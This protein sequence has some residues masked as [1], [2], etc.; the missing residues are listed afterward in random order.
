M[1]PTTDDD[2]SLGTLTLLF[3]LLLGN[4][5]E[6]GASEE[7]L[8]HSTSWEQE[9][10]VRWDLTSCS[11]KLENPKLEVLGGVTVILQVQYGST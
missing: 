7:S 3:F 4:R 1:R 9:L 5:V 6:T 11:E 8:E 10:M 2:C